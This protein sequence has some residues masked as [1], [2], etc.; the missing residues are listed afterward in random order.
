MKIE[1]YNTRGN[2]KAGLL[3]QYPKL[4]NYN[5]QLQGK[6]LY[7]EIK[8]LSDIFQ[9]TRDVCCE[10]VITSGWEEDFAIE[11]YDDYRE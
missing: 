3:E 7:I 5:P 11:I 10:L 2:S 6:T 8:D 9:L 1:I 4:K